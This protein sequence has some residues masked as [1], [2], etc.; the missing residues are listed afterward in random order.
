[1][2]LCLASYSGNSELFPSFFRFGISEPNTI[3]GPDKNFHFSLVTTTTEVINLLC[4]R[5]SLSIYFSPSTI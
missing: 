3:F 4:P 2:A 1:M 5:F